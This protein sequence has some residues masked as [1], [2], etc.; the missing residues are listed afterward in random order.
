MGG[1]YYFVYYLKQPNIAHGRI[2]L[3]APFQ[4]WA[5]N[6]TS[7]CHAQLHTLFSDPLTLRVVPR[8]FIDIEVDRAARGFPWFVP[9]GV[10]VVDP[11]RIGPVTVVPVP[12]N[13]L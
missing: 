9:A 2:I 5:V 6:Q 7:H 8:S 4:S 13:L 12:Q 3:S 11:R 1:L 10:W